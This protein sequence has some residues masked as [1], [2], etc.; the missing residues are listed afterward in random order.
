MLR[1]KYVLLLVVLLV[2]VLTA[3]TDKPQ[4]KEEKTDESNTYVIKAG[5]AAAVDHFGQ[6]TFEK[7]QEIVE[8]NSNGKI[9]V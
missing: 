4:S 6:K 7:F 5:H 3:C 1:K 8:T 9:K 2:S